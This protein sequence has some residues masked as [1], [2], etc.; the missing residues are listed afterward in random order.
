MLNWQDRLEK[1]G[2]STNEAKTYLAL[3]EN[4]PLSCG[5]LC[6]KTGSYRVMTYDT[7]ERLSKRGLVSHFNKNNRRVF[8][9]EP[10]EKMLE[11]IREQ[12]FETRLLVSDLSAL[13]PSSVQEET[14]ILYEGHYGVKTAQENYFA[15]MKTGSGEYLM[16]GASLQLHEKLDAF[17]NFFH[18]RRSQ[19]KVPARLLF[20]ENNRP[21]G[22]L[23]KKYRPVQ[24]RYMPENVITPSWTSI[25]ENEMLIG[26][27]GER[28]VALFT[29]NKQMADSFR[30][31]FEL[32]WKL[33]KE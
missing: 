20:N 4:G 11:A 32:M 3:L 29:K 13:R 6:K 7:I 33:G 17:F 8:R 2:L 21:Y 18:Q 16:F 27:M 30:N 1:A 25:Y 22:Q 19:M 14:V 31:Y 12:E 26:I 10:P 23:K 15:T 5:P 24:V 9:A 28:P